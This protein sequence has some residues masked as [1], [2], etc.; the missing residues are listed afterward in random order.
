ML[1]RQFSKIA[2]IIS[3]ILFLTKSHYAHYQIFNEV[4]K[5]PECNN[6]V[7]FGDI[8]FC[9]PKIDG[10]I[11]SY[12]NKILNKRANKFNKSILILAYYIKQSINLG[13]LNEDEFN[14]LE[15][16]EIIQVHSNEKLKNIKVDTTILNKVANELESNSF[17]KAENWDSLQRKSILISEISKMS[18]SR[19]LLIESYSSTEY[20]R[21]FVL[22]TKTQN[23]DE[24]ELVSISISNLLIINDRMIYLNYIKDYQGRESINKAKAKNDFIIYQCLDANKKN[25]SNEK[26]L[27]RL[28]ANNESTNFYNKGTTNLLNN[29]YETAISNFNKAIEL[30]KKFYE[31]YLNR[32]IAK[33]ELKEYLGAENDYKIAIGIRPTFAGTYY[34]LGI[35]KN[36]T[37]D[38]LGAINAYTQAIKYNNNYDSAYVNRAVIKNFLKDYKGAIEDFT[39]A[40]KINPRFN[41]LYYNRGIAKRN[42]NDFKGAIE[43]Y[44]KAIE[45]K[46]NDP[47]IYYNRG[48]SKRNSKDYYG[49]IADYSNAISLKPDYAKAYYNRA[50]VKAILNDKIG[51]CNDYKKACQLG[52]EDACKNILT[53]CK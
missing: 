9:L 37:N 14:E 22:L 16:N 13:E 51:M 10:F 45:L 26:S 4:Q 48:I 7:K 18:M 28:D 50:Y 2:L 31:A 42:S 53:I 27:L 34:N 21:S 30:N 46:P 17:Y 11:E 15:L 6:V 49:A 40:L 44:T 1:L 41:D 35:L 47:K 23:E 19:P 25:N 33:I 5:N 43:D 32:G 52:E 3:L 8:E 39:K 38:K 24:D 29:Q 20:S 12:S 36:L